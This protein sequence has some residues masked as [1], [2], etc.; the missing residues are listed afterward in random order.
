MGRRVSR[1]PIVSFTG[2]A[3]ERFKG[4]EYVRISDDWQGFMRKY[5]PAGAASILDRMIDDDL[6]FFEK[7]FVCLE[8]ETDYDY[9][10]DALD[11]GC[12]PHWDMIFDC[13]SLSLYNLGEDADEWDVA[14]EAASSYLAYMLDATDEELGWDSGYVASRSSRRSRGARSLRSARMRYILS[15]TDTVATDLFK[16]LEPKNGKRLGWGTKVRAAMKKIYMDQM[17]AQDYDARHFF[18]LVR[19]ATSPDKLKNWGI[20]PGQDNCPKN[21]TKLYPNGIDFWKDPRFADAKAKIKDTLFNTEWIEK[22]QASN[23][24]YSRARGLMSKKKPFK[25]TD[26]L[27]KIGKAGKAFRNPASLADTAVDTASHLVDKLREDDEG[28]V[29]ASFRRGHR[30]LRSRRSYGRG[31]RRIMSASG[32]AFDDWF[33]QMMGWIEDCHPECVVVVE[34]G[35]ADD[36]MDGLYTDFE[37]E[38]AGEMIYMYYGDAADDAVQS[39]GRRLASAGRLARCGRRIFSSFDGSLDE[40]ADAVDRAFEAD[41]PHLWADFEHG[42]KKDY[43]SDYGRM[44]RLHYE[45]GDSPEKAA[46][47]FYFEVGWYAND[48]EARELSDLGVS[49][50]DEYYGVAADDAV[51]SRRI[52]SSF[53]GSFEDY[54]DAVFDIFKRDNSE[55]DAIDFKY[56]CGQGKDSSCYGYKDLMGLYKDGASPDE[57]AYS[58]YFKVRWYQRECELREL[59]DLGISSWDEYYGR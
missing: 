55:S 24:G 17:D 20:V 25:K 59:D 21:F 30:S 47:D 35:M 6:A 48:A 29:S 19:V 45:R 43:A 51:Q 37:P 16:D 27:G 8:E 5:D 56:Y 18:E 46:R 1:R 4:G 2:Y 36:L 15:G 58:M 28:G 54:Y 14:Q 41:S 44:L 22:L 57:A 49:S 26:L 52:A 53:D 10:L 50:W 3:P 33:S 23:Q 11:E 40:Y 42:F 39:R 31:G 34:R 9:Y 12:P 7:F 32:L 13:W 38:D